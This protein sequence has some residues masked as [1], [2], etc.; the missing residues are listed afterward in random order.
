MTGM[1]I[2]R[3]R[4]SEVPIELNTVGYLWHEALSEA[5]S[6]FSIL[7]LNQHAPGVPARVCRVVIAA[8]VV[9]SPVHKLEMAVATNRVHIEEVSRAELPGP[10]LQAA[11]R[12]Q[13]SERKRSSLGFNPFVVERDDR[14]EHS[15]RQVRARTERWVAHY[16]Q[17]GEACQ[18]KSVTDA[19]AACAFDIHQNL[20][21]LR[22]LNASV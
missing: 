2:L 8:V 5:Q 20:G 7:I 3:P 18:S 10:Y 1:S 16:I 21:C 11:D 9:D 19:A 12:K 6:P 13:G 22:Q 14:V 17:V 4:S 15:A